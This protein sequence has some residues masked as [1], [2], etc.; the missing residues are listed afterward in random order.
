MAKYILIR[1]NEEVASIQMFR[2]IV[3]DALRNHNLIMR[4]CDDE[5]LYYGVEIIMEQLDRVTMFSI[6]DEPDEE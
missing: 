3:T 5:D 4:D 1:V 2:Q 6:G